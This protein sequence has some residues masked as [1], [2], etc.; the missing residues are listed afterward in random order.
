MA[1][2][3]DVDGGGQGATLGVISH[4]HAVFSGQI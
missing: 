1:V 2:A 4:F 3:V